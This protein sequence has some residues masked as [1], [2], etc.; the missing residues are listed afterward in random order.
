MRPFIRLAHEFPEG[1]RA[2]IGGEES[3]GTDRKSRQSL[4]KLSGF[5]W[6]THKFLGKGLLTREAFPV[7]ITSLRFPRNRRFFSSRVA[8]FIDGSNLYKG[9]QDSMGRHDLDFGQFV[10]KL[11]GTRCLV[12]AN[13]YN[14]ALPHTDPGAPEQQRFLMQLSR[15][16]HL[17]VMLAK[18]ETRRRGPLRS[19]V[20]K[21]VD[22]AI[23]V[24]MLMLAFSD[25]YDV[26]ILVSGDADFV[27]AVGA[28]RQ[29]GKRVEN[30]Y[31]ARGGSRHLR[32][33]AD[34]HI[35]LDAEYMRECWRG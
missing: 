29:L 20:E 2:G 32:Q 1:F 8:V 25:A 7:T 15:V 27:R 3:R 34:R 11:V 9:C 10:R 35:A 26:A 17:R 21:G 33:V 22:V 14:A 30:A 31:F 4:R 19:Y 16:P 12:G 13:Y 23:V 18:L 24:D 5:L 28:V 6:R